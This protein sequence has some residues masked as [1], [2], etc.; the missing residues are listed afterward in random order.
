M[1]L[2][3][4]GCS[5]T[6][7]FDLTV[8]Q[9]YPAII[10]KRLGC[11]YQEA[12]EPGSCNRR[13]IRTTIQDC[14]KLQGQDVLALIQLSHL[15]RTEYPSQENPL[16]D[17]FFSIKSNDTVY[18]PEDAK[19][20]AEYYWRLHSDQQML[21]NQVTDLIGLVSFFK[22]QNIKYLIYLGPRENDLWAEHLKSDARFRYLNSDPGVVDLTSFY[23]LQETTS[24]RHPDDEG[25]QMIADYFYNRIN[26]LYGSM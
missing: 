17:P 5:Y 10:A 22:Q 15:G 1:I 18:A 9:R 14:L 16:D 2:Y 4:N 3:S 24:D 19:K 8:D 20:Y 23:M 7:N 12:A 6:A 26:L 25:M 21:I 13:I 11:K